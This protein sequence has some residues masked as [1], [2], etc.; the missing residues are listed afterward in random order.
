MGFFREFK[1]FINQ[2]DVMDMA[3][4]IIIGG[5]LTAIVTALTSNIIQPL[6]DFVTG[7]NGEIGGL[8]IPGTNID[9]GAFISACINFLIIAFVVFCLVKAVNKM[10]S[11]GRKPGDEPAV[12]TCPY[13]L[14]EVKVGATRC[15]HCAGVFEAPAAPA[16]TE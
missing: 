15:P 13:C 10:R 9:F 1:E 8:V 2:G 6:I 3:V 7:G 12:P 14:E 11:M 4:G 16:T 5:A